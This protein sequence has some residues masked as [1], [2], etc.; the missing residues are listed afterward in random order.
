MKIA[1]EGCCHGELDKIYETLQHLEKTEG[2]KVDLLLCCGDFQAVRN[3]TDLTCMAVPPKYRQMQ[4]FYKYYSGEKKAP[5]LTVFIGGNHEASNHLWEL[6][7][8][9]WVAPD[10]YYLGYAG[11]VNF[12]GV[13]I[14]GLSGIFKSHEY[15][16]G[17]YEKPPYDDSTLRSAYHIR[18]MDVFNLKLLSQPLDIFLSHDWPRGVYHYGNL[19]DL[20]R[21]KGFLR[22]EIEANTLGSPPAGELLETLQPAYWF[23]A[24]LHT[25]FP[26]LVPH[27]HEGGTRFTKFLALDKCL[28]RRNFLQVVDVGAVEGP[29]E[30]S[31]D[32][33]WLAVVKLTHELTNVTRNYTVLPT[34]VEE[35]KQY[36][37]DEVA[38][39][40]IV[41]LFGGNLT[42][43]KNFVQ[44]VNPYDPSRPTDKVHPPKPV[45]NPQTRRFCAL[46][47]I[48]N[49]S[50]PAEPQDPGLPIPSSNPDE[51]SLDDDEVDGNESREAVMRNPEEIDLE[52][53]DAAEVR[54]SGIEDSKFGQGRKLELHLP[55][56]M[57]LGKTAEEHCRT[58]SVS[59][60]IDKTSR[61][62]PAEDA[63]QVLGS[64][65]VEE[66]D[67]KSRDQE[68]G[69]E[70]TKVMKLI[71]RNQAIY[72]SAQDEE[73]LVGSEHVEEC[74]QKSGDQE[75][76]A[77]PKKKVMKLVRR[78][79]A[80][81]ESAQD[82]E[83]GTEEKWDTTMM[84]A[85]RHVLI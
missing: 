4:T 17:R 59:I 2:I 7:Y 82:E 78:N 12:G 38:V 83:H 49:L 68:E 1:V 74:D 5:V 63:E 55:A 32:A 56:P 20:Y 53:E 45:S 30:L 37:P 39:R 79:Q 19:E 29:M 64:E 15:R 51:I 24:H 50:M 36:R 16:K 41:N 72:E 3:K 48:K 81:Y 35:I 8:G 66:C 67:Q 13:R 58:E 62:I 6:P 34:S 47:G 27:Q 69:A 10:I 9:G 46:L 40:E 54:E 42:V 25:K 22:D 57:N 52:D 61:I 43:P 80:I 70:P 28:P 44:T 33:E 73:Q 14:A 21:Y 76:R 71:R 26:A 65:H 18:S 77:E 85:H 11:V 31:Y 75:E 84:L 60:C 23:A